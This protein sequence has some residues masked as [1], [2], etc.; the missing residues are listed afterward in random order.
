MV[1]GAGLDVCGNCSL[2]QS[3]RS[4]LAACV[5]AWRSGML[6]SM[7]RVATWTRWKG[8]WCVRVEYPHDPHRVRLVRVRSRSGR[9]T[10]VHVVPVPVK[11][12]GR[13]YVYMPEH[14]RLVSW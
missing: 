7:D 10:D 13:G 3:S 1:P 12:T 4:W 2:V 8:V 9:L 14:P 6:A 11:Q 5:G